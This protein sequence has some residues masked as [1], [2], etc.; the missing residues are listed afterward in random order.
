MG[1]GRER[2]GRVALAVARLRGASKQRSLGPQ[3][4]GSLQQHKSTVTSAMHRIRGSEPEMLTIKSSM[5]T[6]VAP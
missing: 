4:T 1:R 5:M 2:E 3:L 6:T